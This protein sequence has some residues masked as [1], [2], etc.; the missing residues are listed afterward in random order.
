M[1]RGKKIANK[2]GG[3]LRMKLNLENCLIIVIIILLCI[4]GY[5]VYNRNSFFFL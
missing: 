3:A 1:P 2:I 5:Q 4:A